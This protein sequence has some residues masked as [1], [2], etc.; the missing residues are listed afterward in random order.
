M[1]LLSNKQ[2]VYVCVSAPY[3]PILY[4][5]SGSGAGPGAERGTA[6]GQHHAA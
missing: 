4:L 1:L 2:H 3:A 6:A 5:L